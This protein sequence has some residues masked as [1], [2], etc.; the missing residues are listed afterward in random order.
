MKVEHSVEVAA[1]PAEAF[2]KLSDV[3]LLATLFS[4]LMD[5]YPTEQPNRFRT[6]LHAGPAPIGGEIELEFFPE[7]ANVTWHATRGIHQM[8]RFLVQRRP[9]GAE[10][11]LRIFYHLDGGLASRVTEWI[12][13]V[14]VHRFVVE[15][16]ERLRQSIEAQPPRRRRP[17]KVAVE[18]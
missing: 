9:I 13:A 1:T 12:T 3:R 6:V 8:G 11:T 5:W 7:S 10:V 15:A 2:A 4:G 16:L 17:D 18:A 14:T